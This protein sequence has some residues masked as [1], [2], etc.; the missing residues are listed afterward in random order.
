MTSWRLNVIIR[1]NKLPR[2]WDQD[3]TKSRPEAARE[4]YKIN[5]QKK[6]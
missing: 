1:L 4:D 5:I 6:L 3:L 2:I